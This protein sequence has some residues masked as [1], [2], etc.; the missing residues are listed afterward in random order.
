[1]KLIFR[2]EKKAGPPEG[3]PVVA[4]AL[5]ADCGREWPDVARVLDADCLN[6]VLLMAYPLGLR[7]VALLSVPWLG[8]RAEWSR[9][10]AGDSLAIE[11]ES[12]MEGV[13]VS[14]VVIE[15]LFEGGQN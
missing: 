7:A 1:M 6:P 12:T 4:V 3:G 9:L 14:V 8:Y 11:A 13:A 15:R 5:V 2:L 10:V